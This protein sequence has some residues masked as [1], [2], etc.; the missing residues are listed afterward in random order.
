MIM[1]AC[2]GDS[3]VRVKVDQFF[4]N[5][6]IDAPGAQRRCDCVHDYASLDYA[7]PIFGALL[8]S[9]TP[10]RSLG[11]HRLTHLSSIALS[12]SLPLFLG[13]PPLYT[14]DICWHGSARG[15]HQPHPSLLSLSLSLS[16]SAGA[17]RMV[18]SWVRRRRSGMCKSCTSGGEQTRCIPL[19]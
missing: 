11:H 14:L 7:N 2:V 18:T 13:C 15:T 10:P 8:V 6:R 5:G 12:P 9:L 1:M 4:V 17:R 16:L 3:L 19:G